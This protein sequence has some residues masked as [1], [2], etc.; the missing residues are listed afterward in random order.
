MPSLAI[1]RRRSLTH[2]VDNCSTELPPKCNPG[3][4]A[5]NLTRRAL[6]SKFQNSLRLKEFRVLRG[7]V[8]GAIKRV[9]HKVHLS[10]HRNYPGVR[11]A[12]QKWTS[13]AGFVYLGRLRRRFV[14]DERIA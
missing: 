6:L 11:C 3:A 13:Y 7:D 9:P 10:Q 2:A 1:P 4:A 8:E 12:P 14:D 5:N